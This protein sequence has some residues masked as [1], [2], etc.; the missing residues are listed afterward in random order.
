V[1][2]AS[3]FG[4]KLVR[5]EYGLPR[6]RDVACVGCRR[7]SMSPRCTARRRAESLLEWRSARTSTPASRQLRYTARACMDRRRSLARTTAR[8]SEQ[9]GERRPAKHFARQVGPRRHG[10]ARVSNRGW[11]VPSET[12]ALLHTHRRRRAA[13]RRTL[14][15]G[16]AGVHG[17]DPPGYRARRPIRGEITQA[18]GLDHRESVP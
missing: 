5:P 7:S 15:C 6:S 16:C 8:A 11:S 14:T 12:G 13:R 17:C 9:Q 2:S 18:V 1:T 3:I 4:A 10:R